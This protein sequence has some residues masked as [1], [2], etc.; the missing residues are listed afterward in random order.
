VE[1]K[2]G[3][4]GYVDSDHRADLNKRRS[5]TGYVFTVGECAVSWRTYLQ[6]RVALS[7]AEAEY[8]VACDASKETV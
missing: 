2:E 7:S 4:V 3:L 5:L 8:V 6:P 1:V